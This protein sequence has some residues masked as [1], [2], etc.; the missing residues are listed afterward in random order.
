MELEAAHLRQHVRAEDHAAL[1]DARDA[2]VRRLR[3]ADDDA[4]RLQRAL[5]AEKAQARAV[6]CVCVCVCLSRGTRARAL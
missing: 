3:S 1:A 5:E 6:V 2:L 4:A